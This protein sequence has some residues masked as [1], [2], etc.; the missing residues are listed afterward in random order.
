MARPSPANDSEKD[1]SGFDFHS[2]NVLWAICKGSGLK[3]PM[4]QG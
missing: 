2:C 3:G 1:I 4:N